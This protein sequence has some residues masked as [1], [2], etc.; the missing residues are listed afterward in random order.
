[1]QVKYIFI[2]P[3][4]Y[5]ESKAHRDPV[6]VGPPDRRLLVLNQGKGDFDLYMYFIYMFNGLVAG[7]VRRA[8]P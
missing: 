8:L 5:I 1:M 7:R 2:Q 6:M 3:W 4:R